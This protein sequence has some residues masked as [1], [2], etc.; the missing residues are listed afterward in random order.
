MSKLL[1]LSVT[2]F[3]YA[4]TGMMKMALASTLQGPCEARRAG[5]GEAARGTERAP[6]PRLP[7]SV[8]Q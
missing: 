4:S 1:H 2:R 8:K 7:L 5:P 3:P 6:C